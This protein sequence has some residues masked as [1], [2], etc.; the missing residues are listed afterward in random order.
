MCLFFIIEL[1]DLL[2]QNLRLIKTHHTKYG[3]S[4][5]LEPLVTTCLLRIWWQTLT[6]EK[7]CYIVIALEYSIYM[8][9]TL[10]VLLIYCIH[11]HCRV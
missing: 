11:V 6:N 3:K 7:T 9:L 10:Y 1:I 2:L 4:F 5:T 8:Y